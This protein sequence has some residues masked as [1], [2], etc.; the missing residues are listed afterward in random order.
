MLICTSVSVNSW[1][2]R[3]VMQISF[4]MI[5]FQMKFTSGTGRQF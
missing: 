5:V 4:K 3:C 2:V 1:F